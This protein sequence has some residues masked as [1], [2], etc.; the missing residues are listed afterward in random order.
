MRRIRKRVTKYENV[1]I[2]DDGTEFQ[3]ESDAR[4]YE[5]KVKREALKGL[6]SV[7]NGLLPFANAKYTFYHAETLEDYNKILAYFRVKYG[8]RI[9][10]VARIM[11][12]PSFPEWY[13]VFESFG[14]NTEDDIHIGDCLC[15]TSLSN[16]N[17]MIEG[18]RSQLPID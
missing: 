14:E 3:F 13:G 2:A 5:L 1:F 16:F 12:N 18:F 7:E 17:K 8:D 4:E 10:S 15:F 6:E 11:K 9:N